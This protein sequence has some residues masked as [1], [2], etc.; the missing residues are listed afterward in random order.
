MKIGLDYWR[1]CSH[2][3]EYF[4]ELAEMHLRSGN[5]VYIISA[6]GKHRAGTVLG[7]VCN[8]DIPFTSVHEVIFSHPSESP[9]LKLAKCQELEITVF[10]DDREDVC[11]FLVQ[12]GILAFRVPRLG[13]TSD[14][15]SERC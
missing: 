12:A 13:R 4:R 9:K 15:E 2:Y 10:Y 3:P 8:L 6:V 7:E 14:I 5:D 1:V 11:S